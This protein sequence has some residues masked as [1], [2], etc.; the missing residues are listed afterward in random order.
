VSELSNLLKDNSFSLEIYK[1]KIKILDVEKRVAVLEDTLAV[2]RGIDFRI[3]KNADEIH[4]II[5]LR[6]KFDPNMKNNRILKDNELFPF[7]S[8]MPQEYYFYAE[9]YQVE[10]NV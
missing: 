9:N 7:L 8:L 4:M 5:A 6:E 3:I 1:N 10:I 2:L